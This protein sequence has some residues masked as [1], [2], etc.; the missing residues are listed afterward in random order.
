MVQ[1]SPAL[2]PV[3]GQLNQGPRTPAHM[4]AAVTLFPQAGKIKDVMW[5][6]FSPSEAVFIYTVILC[7]YF[8]K[9]SDSVNMG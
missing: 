3:N 5:P 1:M 2:P 6:L 9:T 8:P 7:S 4:T